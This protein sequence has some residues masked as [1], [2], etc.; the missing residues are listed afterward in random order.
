V[1]L[2][3]NHAVNLANLQL[4]VGGVSDL[5]LDLLAWAP[6]RQGC[7]V[8]VLA[9]QGGGEL[10]TIDKF[11]GKSGERCDEVILVIGDHA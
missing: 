1:Q 7:R 3:L 8:L 10:H 11:V 5:V 4:A 2:K 6:A 9:A